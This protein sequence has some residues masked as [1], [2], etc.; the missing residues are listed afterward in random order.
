MIESGDRSQVQ[1][2]GKSATPALNQKTVAS[3]RHLV[4][5]PHCRESR[6]GQRDVWIA[7]HVERS[8]TSLDF[9]LPYRRRNDPRFFASLRMTTADDRRKAT[10]REICC[11][12]TLLTYHL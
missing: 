5:A 9:G 10:N 4:A 8:E 2:F 7:C 6:R 11:A 1:L 12:A 3:G